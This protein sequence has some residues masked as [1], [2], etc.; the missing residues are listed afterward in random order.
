MSQF[1]GVIC[2]KAN[3]KSGPSFQKIQWILHEPSIFE[4]NYIQLI[5]IIWFENASKLNKNY[6]DL[7]HNSIKLDHFQS[8]LPNILFYIIF[9]LNV[10]EVTTQLVHNFCIL[11]SNSAEKR[12]PLPSAKPSKKIILLKTF[13]ASTKSPLHNHFA[14]YKHTIKYYPFPM[15][16]KTTPQFIVILPHAL[17]TF[18]TLAFPLSIIKF[19]CYFTSNFVL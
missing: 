17:S 6:I 14:K 16:H 19:S 5:L 12:F 18:Y 8:G 7:L 11:S 15:L 9:W 10:S 3:Q 13:H 1:S 2:P 4:S